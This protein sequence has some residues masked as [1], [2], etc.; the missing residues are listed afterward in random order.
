[1]IR[2]AGARLE[3]FAAHDV[4]IWERSRGDGFVAD[5]PCAPKLDRAGARAYNAPFIAAFPT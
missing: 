5:Y 2:V 1:M 4:A 3:A